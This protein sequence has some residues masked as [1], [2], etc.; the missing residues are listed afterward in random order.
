VEERRG[1]KGQGRRDK[2]EVDKESQAAWRGS[3][4]AG[5]LIMSWA[6]STPTTHEKRLSNDSSITN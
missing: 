1:D 5:V 6:M 3:S 4:R 2:Q